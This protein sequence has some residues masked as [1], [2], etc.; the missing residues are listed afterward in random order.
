VENKGRHLA[1]PRT[2]RALCPL[3]FDGAFGL[4]KDKHAI[5]VCPV[6]NRG[7]RLIT[8]FKECHK[9]TH[10]HA[11]RVCQAVVNELDPRTTNLF[12]INEVVIDHD[13]FV[14]C[15]FTNNMIGLIGCCPTK[16]R[17]I[18]C[19]SPPML[20]NRLK[21]HLRLYHQ[22]TARDTE[23]VLQFYKSKLSAMN[24]SKDNRSTSK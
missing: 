24:S 22:I 18:P 14:A 7:R 2:I 11:L 16:S 1:D 3:T 12:G 21:N 8:H 4:T 9:L 17:F 5:Q 10:V 23:S 13:R 19:P 20:D 15:P 6:R